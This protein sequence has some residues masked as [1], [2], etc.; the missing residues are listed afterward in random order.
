MST[1]YPQHS[2]LHYL[3]NS[4]M[5]LEEL[6]WKKG[7]LESDLCSPERFPIMK[8][9][10]SYIHHTQNGRQVS[11]QVSKLIV[12]G[13]LRFR[14]IFKARWRCHQLVAPHFSTL[15]WKIPWMEEPGGLQTMGLHRVRHDWSDLAAAAAALARERAGS[16]LM[17]GGYCPCFPRQETVHFGKVL[18]NE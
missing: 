18:K 17:S 7:Y 9:I 1:V 5:Y 11:S 16:S 8:E 13:C 14:R 4:P 6:E 12:C 10:L 3:F 2:P 15:A